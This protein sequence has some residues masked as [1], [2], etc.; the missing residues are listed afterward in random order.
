VTGSGRACAAVLSISESTGCTMPAGGFRGWA[1][2]PLQAQ[3]RRTAHQ[4]A[5]HKTHALSA[6][7]LNQ[8]RADSATTVSQIEQYVVEQQLK[9]KSKHQSLTEL[10]SVMFC[11]KNSCENTQIPEAFACMRIKGFCQSHFREGAGP[12]KTTF[13]DVFNS[14]WFAQS[15]NRRVRRTTSRV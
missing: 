8:A 1:H 14:V 2:C 12:Q 10:Y 6:R 9:H 5:L 4:E 7:F 11:P 13:L 15:S 3:E